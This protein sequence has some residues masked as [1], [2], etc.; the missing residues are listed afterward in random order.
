MLRAG[1]NGREKKLAQQASLAKKNHHI[2]DGMCDSHKI[3]ELLLPNGPHG[4]STF[5]GH[6]PS[7]KSCFLSWEEAGSLKKEGEGPRET[8]GQSA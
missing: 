6:K 7:E 4:C 3:Q 1:T 5:P 2:W 8:T